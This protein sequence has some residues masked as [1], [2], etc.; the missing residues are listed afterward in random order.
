M[1]NEMTTSDFT[2][3]ISVELDTG[4]Y[5]F[6]DTGLKKGSGQ[7][8]NSPRYDYQVCVMKPCSK[9]KVLKRRSEFDERFYSSTGLTSQCKECRLQY[10]QRPEVKERQKQYRQRSEVREKQRLYHQRPEV[11]EKKQQYQQ[12]PE[13]K[14][15]QKEYYQRPEVIEKIKQ[16]QQKPE[17]K[18]KKKQYYQRQEVKEKKKQND[19]RRRV[20]DK[21]LSQ[22]YRTESLPHESFSKFL[23]RVK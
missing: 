22:R 6:T 2:K 8:W 11:K 16:Y 20:K 7:K 13:I 17:T 4:V 15:R 3:Y 14:E 21:I 10:N 23:R 19:Q 12:S 18:E 9:C 5:P 1:N